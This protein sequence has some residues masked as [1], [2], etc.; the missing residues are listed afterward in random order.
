M[1]DKWF[2]GRAS[3]TAAG[4]LE[5]RNIYFI[6]VHQNKVS[7]AVLKK[8]KPRLAGSGSWWEPEKRA[9]RR[10]TDGGLR[11]FISSGLL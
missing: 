7:A 1:E 6:L 8:Q 4:R 2:Y 5:P 11:G 9:A 3:R 10:E